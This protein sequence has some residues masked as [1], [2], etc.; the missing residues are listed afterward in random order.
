MDVTHKPLASNSAKN[1]F[2]NQPLTK[3]SKITLV[4]ALI[5]VAIT[6]FA[7]ALI[8]GVSIYGLY[9]HTFTSLNE[10]LLSIWEGLPY[11]LLSLGSIDLLLFFGGVVYGVFWVLNRNKVELIPYVQT[12]QFVEAQDKLESFKEK[13]LEALERKSPSPSRIMLSPPSPQEMEYLKEASQ[14]FGYSESK[15]PEGF[16]TFRGQEACCV[17]T[18]KMP[19]VVLKRISQLNKYVEITRKAQ[20]ICKDHNL[21]LLHVP[22]ALALPEIILERGYGVLL[23]ERVDLISTSYNVI[24]TYYHSVV[25]D[26]SLQNY[27]EVLFEQMTLFVSL[28]NY[29]D[30]KFDNI[31]FTN[32][33]EV[34]LYDLDESGAYTS[35]AT[36]RCKNLQKTGI[37]REIPLAWVDKLSP[38]VKQH[39]IKEQWDRFAENLDDLKVAAE[40]REA[41]IV[42]ANSFYEE[43]GIKFPDQLL[44]YDLKRLRGDRFVRKAALL[45]IKHINLAIPTLKLPRLSTGR[46]VGIDCNTRDAFNIEMKAKGIFMSQVENAIKALIEA[47]YLLSYSFPGRDL[48]SSSWF[49]VVC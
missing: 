5:L 36:G 1:F 27:G 24:G 37:F 33:G 3:L 19:H 15:T 47:N 11:T 7:S 44:Q 12:P 23:Q 25:T 39:A 9:W 28:L 21:Y 45:V 34:G 49:H 42:K 46:E 10:L 4:V 2:D 18:D 32:A 35:L 40:K 30:W 38:I 31:G 14:Y 22:D 26:P 6:S 8:G 48:Y 13:A 16:K 41:Q 20:Q 29:S 43:N 17:V